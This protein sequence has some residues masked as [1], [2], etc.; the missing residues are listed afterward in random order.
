MVVERNEHRS[1]VKSIAA[2]ESTL[3]TK[4][5]RSQICPETHQA[6]VSEH[7]LDI[8]QRTADRGRLAGGLRREGPPA[9]VR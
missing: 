9:A 5:P 1:A 3:G 8:A 6:G 4:K 7:V 2:P